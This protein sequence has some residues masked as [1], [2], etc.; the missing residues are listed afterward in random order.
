[1][2]PPVTASSA[3]GTPATAATTTTN[4]TTT[5]TTT[6]TNTTE[7]LLKELSA[8]TPSLPLYFSGTAPAAC[9]AG[10]FLLFFDTGSS[11]RDIGGRPSL[12]VAVPPV[13]SPPSVASAR[14]LLQ[15]EPMWTDQFT[16]VRWQLAADGVLVPTRFAAT[17]QLPV[18]L[19]SP[20]TRVALYARQSLHSGSGAAQLCLLGTPHSPL[21]FQLIRLRVYSLSTIL[22]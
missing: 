12:S 15:L 17:E 21:L 14:R 10:A 8:A 20:T 1:M 19:L 18:V 4:T 9:A 5:T 13:A 6:T 16:L 11:A 2:A 7:F 22:H 3:L